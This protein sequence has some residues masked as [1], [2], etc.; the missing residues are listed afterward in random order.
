MGMRLRRVAHEKL[1]GDEF[2]IGPPKN[3]R[4]LGRSTRYEIRR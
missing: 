4:I 2:T 3:Q 1:D